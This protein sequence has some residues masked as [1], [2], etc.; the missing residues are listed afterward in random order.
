MIIIEPLIFNLIFFGGLFRFVYYHRHY[1][2]IL[3]SIEFMILSLY[4]YICL[5]NITFMT[6]GIFILLFLRF[7]VCEGRLGLGIL[8]IF[9]RFQGNDIFFT[10]IIL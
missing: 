1:L 8:I 2:R 7:I 10:N 9:T 6:E 4:S 3:L 5:Y